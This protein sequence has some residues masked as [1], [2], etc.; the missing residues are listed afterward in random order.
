ME[1]NDGKQ[2]FAKAR[3]VA[4]SKRACDAGAETNGNAY[5]LVARTG[6]TAGGRHRWTSAGQAINRNLADGA[7][8]RRIQDLRTSDA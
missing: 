4:P 1:E 5:W 7:T 8:R 6:W 2:G 3:P